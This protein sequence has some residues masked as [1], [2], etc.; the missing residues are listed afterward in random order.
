MHVKFKQSS[1]K[2]ESPRTRLDNDKE[3]PKNQ[4]TFKLVITINK[5]YVFSAVKSNQDT[6]LL[7]VIGQSSSPLHN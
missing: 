1:H 3:L 6:L 4:V 2:W 7:A 5:H